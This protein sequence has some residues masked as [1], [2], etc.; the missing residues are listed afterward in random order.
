MLIIMH[1]SA[2]WWSQLYYYY[3]DVC[4]TRIQPILLLYRCL[5]YEDPTYIIIMQM[6]AI[7]GSNLYHYY[8]DVCHTRIQ[9]TSLLWKCLPYEDLSC[10]IIMQM[11]T[12]RGSDLH[13][14]Y[15]D[16]CHT[17]AGLTHANISSS[18]GNSPWKFPWWWKSSDVF[19][20]E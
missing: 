5:P 20:Y 11:Y 3:T 7:R 13:R 17:C 2:I 8:A 9:P 16:V 10:I 15:G 18:Q 14:Y 6:S 1:M 4:H 19:E 12:I